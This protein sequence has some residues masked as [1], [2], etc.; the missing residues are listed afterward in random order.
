VWFI[1][2]CLA[3]HGTCQPQ[4]WPDLLEVCAAGALA[5]AATIG[6]IVGLNLLDDLWWG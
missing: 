2:H 4:S 6:L 3:F 1:H 5:V